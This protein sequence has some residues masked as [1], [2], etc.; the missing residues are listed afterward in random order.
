[1]QVQMSGF[2]SGLTPEAQ[3]LLAETPPQAL[4]LF[5]QMASELSPAN[6]HLEAEREHKEQI[7]QSLFGKMF[8]A[9]AE[10]KQ[11]NELL[12]AELEAFKHATRE[13]EAVLEARMQESEARARAE[14]DA[15]TAHVRQLQEQIAALNRNVDAFGSQL[16]T[17]ID[18]IEGRFKRHTHNFAICCIH[19]GYNCSQTPGR[20]TDVPNA[21][22]HLNYSG[23]KGCHQQ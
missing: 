4:Q 5:S 18:A 17:R 3:S 13:K 20:I 23:R 22:P 11:Q 7:T 2:Q 16:N 15:S 10:V 12:R 8:A 21:E 9:F 1:M 19:S 14:K 6:Q